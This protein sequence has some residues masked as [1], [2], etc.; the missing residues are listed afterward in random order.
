MKTT[1]TLYRER[2]AHRRFKR[3]L[4][5]EIEQHLGMLIGCGLI[6]AACCGVLLGTK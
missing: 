1:E 5:R 6:F 2:A 3:Q 4:Q